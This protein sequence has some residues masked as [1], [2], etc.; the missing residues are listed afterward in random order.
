MKVELYPFQAEFI[1]TKH[2]TILMS[3]TFGSGK[4]FSL[5]HL[6]LRLAQLPK[7]RILIT[8]KH[9]KHLKNTT[10]K[11]FLE[12]VLP[13]RFILKHNKIDHYLT[14]L[15]GTEIWF[16]GIDQYEKLGSYEYGA[17]LVDEGSELNFEDYLMLQSR[18]RYPKVS[19]HFFAIVTNPSSPH[20]WIYKEFIEKGKHKIVY[21]KTVWRFLPESYKERLNLLTGKWRER[22]VEGKWIGFEDVVFDCFDPRKHILEKFDFEIKEFKGGIDWG[23]TN[24][25]C[26]QI[27]AVFEDEEVEKYCLI[28][29]YYQTK[30]EPEII[31][32]LVK[33]EYEKLSKIKK[34]TIYAGADRPDMISQL[35]TKN[36]NISAHHTYDIS[37]E[38]Q[39]LY[40]LM[41]EDRI[42][43]LKNA[44]VKEDFSLRDK[45]LPIST[46]DEIVKLE[47]DVK[48]ERPKQ[49]NDHGFSA[50][51]YALLSQKKIEYLTPSLVI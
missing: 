49:E 23:F 9:F 18:L 38:T 16:I 20:H 32:N 4:T 25:F 19:E 51:R 11:K 50:M 22:Y 35:K 10:M 27:W 40:N 2:P 8:R 46:L 26:F 29:E 37:K 6:A 31:I 28:K 1:F 41:N 44:L 47:W 48:R 36:V 21:G 39:A 34:F 30:L 7:N 33:K 42:L 14:L 43:F 12:E 13:K 45:K 15:N 17:I 5:C 3:G 24:P